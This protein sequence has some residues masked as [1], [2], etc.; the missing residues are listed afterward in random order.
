M[1]FHLFMLGKIASYE[2]RKMPKSM[3]ARVFDFIDTHRLSGY[4]LDDRK[5]VLQNLTTRESVRS[6]ALAGNSS[7]NGPH[8]K[9]LGFEH[10]VLPSTFW[11]SSSGSATFN[12]RSVNR[13][14]WAGHRLEIT[15]L[16]RHTKSMLSDVA[17]K[18]ISEDAVEDIIQLWRAARGWMSDSQCE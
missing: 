11:S 8:V 13:G 1:T 6:E 5:W 14:I 7:Q 3:V 18:N 16:Y 9:D 4:F 10:I 12:G 17:W 15:M 2:M